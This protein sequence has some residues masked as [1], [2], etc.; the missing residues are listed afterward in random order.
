MVFSHPELTI[1][2][3][4]HNF[5]LVITGK[6]YNTVVKNVKS[7]RQ[8]FVGAEYRPEEDKRYT[9]QN[10]ALNTSILWNYE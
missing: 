2:Q 4:G 5:F 7:P 10:N 6:H 9:K 1:V 3:A 8:H